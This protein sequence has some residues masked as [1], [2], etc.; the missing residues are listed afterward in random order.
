MR[1]SIATGINIME[2]LR[3]HTSGYAVP[4]YVVDAPGGGG[5]IPVAPNYVITQS[6]GEFTLRNYKGE[7]Y[8]Y[9]EPQEI[10]ATK[11]QSIAAEEKHVSKTA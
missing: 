11:Q 2:K 7:I 8:T 10:I 9:K 6:K 3:G 1:T 5:K 4:T